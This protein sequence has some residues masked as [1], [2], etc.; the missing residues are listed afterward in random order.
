MAFLTF[1]GATRQVTGSCFLLEHAGQRLLLDCGMYQGGNETEAANREEFPFIPAEIDAVLLSHAHLDHCGLLPKLVKE[2]FRG[3][4]YL[5]PATRDLLRLMLEDAAH[6]ENK[7]TEWENRQRLR[8]GDEPIEPLFDL[9]DVDSVLRQCRSI[10]YQRPEQ[11]LPGVTVTFRDAGHILGSA[12]VELQLA[13]RDGRRRL[14]FSGDLGNSGSALLRDPEPIDGADLLLL[15]STYGD[16]CH[17]TLDATLQELK[18][19]LVTAHRSGGNVL[20]PAFAVGRTQE[21]LYWLGQFDRQGDLPQQQVFLDSPMA[22]S[23]SEIYARHHHLFSPEEQRAFARTGSTEWESWLPKLRYSRT[24]ADSMALNQ[25]QGGAIIIAGSGMC[26]GGRIRHH[27]KHGLWRRQNHL[28]IV[29]F[30]ARGT[31]GRLLVDGA[32][33]VRLFGQEIA[34]N[35]KIHTV[36]GFSAHADQRQ[37][38]E[39]AGRLRDPAPKLFLVHGELE[40]MVTLQQAIHEQLGWFAG[41]PVRGQKIEL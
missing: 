34:V 16:R 6:L 28:L 5:T 33:R 17:R 19:I 15:E 26:S 36:G 4:I 40:P 31:L 41:I 18:E 35:A 21:L 12:T 24:T 10:D 2:G 20:I 39:W 1:Y 38:I 14:L 25:I 37:L 7:D 29:G 32:Q 11:I 23:A 9:Q 30:Q 3:P 22:I 13:S 8:S 27:L